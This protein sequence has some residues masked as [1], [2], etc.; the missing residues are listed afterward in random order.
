[1]DYAQEFTV[2]RMC[3]VLKVSKSGYYK[4]RNNIPKL[5]NKE[6]ELDGDYD[7]ILIFDLKI[8]LNWC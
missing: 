2:E 6:S 3:R 7:N 1:M 4:W 8:F 5:K